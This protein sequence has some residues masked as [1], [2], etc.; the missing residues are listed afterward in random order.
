MEGGE[1][2]IRLKKDLGGFLLTIFS[3]KNKVSLI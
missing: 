1:E 3:F 2:V